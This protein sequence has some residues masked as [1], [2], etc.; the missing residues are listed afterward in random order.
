MSPPVRAFIH[1]G[2]DYAGPFHLCLTTGRK[3]KTMESY[4][5]VF[6]CLSTKAIHLEMSSELSTALFL[7]ALKRFVS[8]RGV[9]STILSDG[10]R[11][12]LGAKNEIEE[13]QTFL[14]SSNFNNAMTKYFVEQ[15]IKFTM[16]PPYSPHHGGIFEAGVKS[17]KTH[18]HRVTQ[19]RRLSIEEFSTL[20]AEIEAVLN[21]RPLVP[22][23]FK[24][25]PSG[26]SNGEENSSS[27]SLAACPANVSAFF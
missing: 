21:S 15:E 3:P 26:K 25:N 14:K 4:V 12:F 5:C 18:L 8:R 7:G 1:I 27:I 20:L 6:I 10:G 16:N 13:I 2:V 11:N 19:D 22:M 24:G 23:I 17:F 9:P